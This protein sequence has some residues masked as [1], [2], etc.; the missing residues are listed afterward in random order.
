MPLSF[1]LGE[2]V[3]RVVMTQ[4]VFH[5]VRFLVKTKKSREYDE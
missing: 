2:R 5:G 3:Q 4:K 1:T